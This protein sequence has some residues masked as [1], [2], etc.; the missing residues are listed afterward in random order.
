MP[1]ATPELHKPQ[2]RR[3]VLVE[4]YQDEATAA[5]STSVGSEEAIRKWENDMTAKAGIP[6]GGT[7][8][9]LPAISSVGAYALSALDTVVQGV[10]SIVSSSSGSSSTSS[11]G[12][13]GGV[14]LSDYYS[15]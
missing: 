6:D 4:A 9:V 14:P 3:S 8:S 12:S 5:D 13:S 7:N 1:Q 11:S 2:H 10:R 15:R